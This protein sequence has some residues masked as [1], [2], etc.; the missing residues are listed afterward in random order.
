MPDHNNGFI[1]FLKQLRDD[2]DLRRKYNEEPEKFLG[3]FDINQE[4]ANQLLRYQTAEELIAG[5]EDF[6][7]STVNEAMQGNEGGELTTPSDAALIPTDQ[8]GVEHPVAEL[9][10]QTGLVESSAS[11]IEPERESSMTGAY[12]WVSL[13][14]F[15]LVM[16]YWALSQFFPPV[17]QTL[18]LPLWGQ[19]H[20][21]IR[22]I[23]GIYWFIAV[24]MVVAGTV[25]RFTG[26]KRPT[27]VSL[28]IFIVVLIVIPGSIILSSLPIANQ[29]IIAQIILTLVFTAVPASFYPMFI[30][31]KGKTLWEE[32]MQNLR[33]LDPVGYKDQ[34]SIY[35]KKFIALYGEIS[36]GG[37]GQQIWTGEKTFPVLLNTLIVGFGW[38]LF[39]LTVERNTT[40]TT[41]V[42]TPFTFGFLGAYMFSLQMLFRRYVQSDLKTTAYTHSSQ[43]ILITWVWA[44]ILSIL[45]W[46]LVRLDPT[47][48]N[49]IISVLAFVVGIFPDIALQVIGRFM[50]LTLGL[51]IPSFRQE[52]P[53]N[54]IN[55]ITVWV[56]ARLLEENIEN[57]QNLVTA[58]IPDLMLRTNLQP[59]RI[60]DWIDQGILRVH[61]AQKN[62]DGNE[63]LSRTL[64]ERGV[65]KATDLYFSHQ[66]FRERSENK[67]RY[68]LS[69]T[70]DPKVRAMID[71]FEDD[72]NMYHIRAWRNVFKKQTKMLPV[73]I[74]E[75]MGG[76]GGDKG[77]P[78]GSE[79]DTDEGELQTSQP[80][81][82]QP[83]EAEE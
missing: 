38:L 33:F 68:F 58:R 48:Q 20:I 72:T 10:T 81:L 80:T 49:Q 32:F 39:F 22:V 14:Y 36:A 83:A 41:G 65:I 4:V 74:E 30:T 54:E 27:R 25:S 26:M 52:H 9:P 2:P 11:Q 82:A 63:N 79:T 42:V 28:W 21:V 73:A 59:G 77:K 13:I 75:L 34:E 44:F 57:I 76:T 12:Y 47:Y 8:Q 31:S 61:L 45:P 29:I 7:P 35:Y 62:S 71:S 51:V 40:I 43:R 50:K 66:A 46:D 18:G 19:I 78:D 60:V 53:L 67:D 23:I 70:L 17:F 56:E 15:L 37:F 6:L 64:Q 55:G 16:A 3:Q 5:S 24:G 1:E 69:K